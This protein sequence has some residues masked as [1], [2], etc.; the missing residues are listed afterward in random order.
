MRILICT[1]LLLTASFAQLFGQFQ[2]E[3]NKGQWDKQVLYR[4]KIPGGYCYITKSGLKYHYLSLDDIEDLAFHHLP[5]SSLSPG[6]KPNMLRQHAIEVKFLNMESNFEIIKKGVSDVYSNYFIGNDPSMWQ[7]NVR[8]YDEVI[9]K[10][11]YPGID[12]RFYSKNGGLKYDFIVH[13]GASPESIKLEYSGAEIIN[14]DDD[15]L[16]I[17]HRFGYSSEKKPIAYQTNKKQKLEEVACEYLLRDNTLGFELK[18]GYK[19]DRDLII[20]PELIFS[21][22][23]GSTSDNWG[24]TA[25]FDEMGNGFSGGIVFGAGFPTTDGAFDERFNGGNIDIGILKYDSSGTELIYATYVG[26]AF[27]ETVQSMIVNS[28]N[29]LIFYGTTSSPDFPISDNAIQSEFK[30]GTP[31]DGVSLAAPSGLIFANGSDMFV[32][33]LNEEGTDFFWGHRK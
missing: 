8:K 29:E 30:G 6:S 1:F 28:R 20:D 31:M 24:F 7:T 13:S 2:F 22:Y 16:M 21:T 12:F 14:M 15:D 26:G 9:L 23:S 5:E 25:T 33:K 4:T 11:I 32:A 3:E 27:A 19:G 10:N 18:S 17:Q